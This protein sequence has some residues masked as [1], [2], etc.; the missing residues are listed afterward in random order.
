MRFSC[1]KFLNIDYFKNYVGTYTT[2]VCRIILCIFLLV[3][4]LLAAIVV[5]ASEEELS[6][7]CNLPK[8][9]KKMNQALGF[10]TCA[11]FLFD[12]D[13]ILTNSA[14]IQANADQIAFNNPPPPPCKPNGRKT[15]HVMYLGY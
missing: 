9:V 8:R 14:A 15:F 10:P 13:K 2:F 11:T 1:G 12:I 7:R 6:A 5:A 4:A 3:F